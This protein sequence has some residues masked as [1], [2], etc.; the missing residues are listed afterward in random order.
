M[1]NHMTS[2]EGG[3][4]CLKG[5]KVAGILDAAEKG[6]EELPN[7]DPFH[8]IDPLA[9]VIRWKKLMV[10]SPKQDEVCIFLLSLMKMMKIRNTKM[11]MEIFLM[12]SMKKVTMNNFN[13]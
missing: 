13:L 8:D 3:D 9:T 2:S 5:W 7:L 10:T 11:K 6:L 4:V 12:Y 1:Y